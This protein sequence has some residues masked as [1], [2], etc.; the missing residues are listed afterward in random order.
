MVAVEVAVGSDGGRACWGTG[1]RGRW[2]WHSEAG[3]S[4]DDIFRDG[5]QIFNTDYR[6]KIAKNILFHRAGM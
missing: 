6:F 5:Q 3:E 1:G 4:R 2:R